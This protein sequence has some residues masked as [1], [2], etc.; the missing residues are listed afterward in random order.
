MKGREYIIFCDESVQRGPFY[1]NFYG[2]LLLDIVHYQDV[3]EALNACKAELNLHGEIKWSKVTENYQEKYQT[4]MGYFFSLILNHGIKVRLMFRQNAHIPTRFAADADEDPYFLLYYQFLKHA[5]GLIYLPTEEPHIKLRVYLDELP[6]TQ[7]KVAAFKSH[8]LQI[9]NRIQHTNQYTQFVLKSEDIA[10]VNSHEH[11]LLQC[12]DVVLGAM[13]W[14]LNN[15]HKAKPEGQRIRGKR[16]IAK[17]KLYKFILSEICKIR[18]H[19]NIGISTGVDG[20]LSNRW[21]HP[22]RHWS[23]LPQEAIY[24]KSLTKRG[25]TKNENDPSLPT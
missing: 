15:G 25:G 5:F 2:G 6:D 23:F 10:D 17:E 20:D 24:E 9:A 11:V 7:A 8:V 18:P 13:A 14:R 4:L 19:F 1:S 3:T 12:L 16:T 21:N 22:Y